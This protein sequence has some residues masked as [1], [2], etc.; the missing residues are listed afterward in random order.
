VGS[1]ARE[2]RGGEGGRHRDGG[3][4]EASMMMTGGGEDMVAL[5]CCVDGSARRLISWWA[6]P[7]IFPE[8]IERAGKKP[9]ALSA[10]RGARALV[11]N[12]ALQFLFFFRKNSNLIHKFT[13]SINHHKY[14]QIYIEVFGHLTTTICRQSEPPTDRCCHSLTGVSMTLSIIVG[15]SSCTCPRAKVVAI[16]IE[17]LN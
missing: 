1:G 3:G 14:N 11:G 5:V 2:R 16:E 13:A 8:P 10:P 15:K 6:F 9:F 7:R 4:G 12:L 17:P